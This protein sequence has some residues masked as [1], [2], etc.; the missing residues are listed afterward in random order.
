MLAILSVLGM[1][2][3]E[4]YKDEGTGKTTQIFQRA[5]LVD[6]GENDV[7]LANIGEAINQSEI[8]AGDPS[9]PAAPPMGGTARL[10]NSPEGLRLRSGPSI[11]DEIVQVLPDA[12]EFIIGGDATAA[13]VADMPM[14][15]RDGSRPSF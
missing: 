13:W 2:L 5:V 11:K 6:H 15:I 7:R 12:A 8:D 1:P 4:P 10:I 9:F 3:S 14:G